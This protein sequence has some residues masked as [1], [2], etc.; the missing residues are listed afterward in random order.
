VLR[1]RYANVVLVENHLM[2][3]SSDT[4]LPGVL[5]ISP[6][7]GIFLDDS[8]IHGRLTSHPRQYLRFVENG[9]KAIANGM[10]KMQ[11]PAKQVFSD[12][13]ERSDFR[14]MPCILRRGSGVRKT[15]KLVGT[16]TE[17]VLVPGQ[18]TVGRTFALHPSENF[19]THT[20][21]ACLLS[22]AR[23]G[24]CAVLASKLLAEDLRRVAIIGAGRVAYYTA[25]YL[26]ALN[27]TE[28]LFLADVDSARAAAMVATLHAD[29]AANGCRIFA[30][31]ADGPVD[32]VILATTSTAP[33]CHRGDFEARLV[34]SLGAD[35]VSQHELAADF[36]NTSTIYVDTRDSVRYG[37]LN[38]WIAAGLVAEESLVDMLDLMRNGAAERR[39]GPRLFV[40]TGTALFDNLT[41]G[42]LL[43]QSGS[44]TL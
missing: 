20:F 35:S 33:V 23:T 21:D 29:G 12:P 44:D 3:N 39:D 32:A 18:I 2:D 34:V 15:V 24:A 37:D 13:D 19:V 43:S 7:P 5:R 42:Y 31:A 22:S 4:S 41:V 40:S 8:D 16:N 17:Q 6:E 27:R 10:V 36:A 28:T 30:G 9:L 11:L 14:V 1:L 25:R 38:A 26:F